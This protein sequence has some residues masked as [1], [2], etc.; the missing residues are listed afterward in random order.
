MI[1]KK[2]YNSIF[3]L[4]AYSVFLV[5]IVT[6]LSTVIIPFF[7]PNLKDDPYYNS[8]LISSEN[9]VAMLLGMFIKQMLDEKEE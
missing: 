7:L 4:A 6:Q 1:S 2:Q 8:A 9:L 3:K 5:Y